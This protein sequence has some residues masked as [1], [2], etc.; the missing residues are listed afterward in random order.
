MLGSLFPRSVD[1]AYR[2]QSLALWFF[3]VIVILKLCL[4]LDAIFNGAFM[5]RAGDGIP[6][7]TFAPADSQA[8]ISLYALWGLEHAVICLMCL[9][10]LFRYRT[11]IPFLYLLLL[12]EQLSRKLIV[13]RFSPLSAVGPARL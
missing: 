2:G 9:F 10:A 3:A 13:L 8:V 6:L 7:D 5:A 12:L 4:S 1:N 11:F